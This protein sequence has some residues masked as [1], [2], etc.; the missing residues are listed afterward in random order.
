MT[1]FNE[2]DE[3]G[4]WFAFFE[5]TVD[6]ESLEI[7]YKEPLENA[8][9]FRVR[10]MVPF[11]EERRKGRKKESKFVANPQT[12]AME[13]VS[14]YPDLSPEEEEKEMNAAWNYAIT[15]IRNAFWSENSPIE[16]TI[17]NKLKLIK[18]PSVRRFFTRVFQMIDETGIKEKETEEKN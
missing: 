14:Y 7:T 16:C 10:S 9:E 12:R 2:K 4:D 5:S 18:I 15:D 8:A 13:R 11:F 3:Q 17:E 6:S 1:Y